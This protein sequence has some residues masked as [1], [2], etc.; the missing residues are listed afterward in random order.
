MNGRKRKLSTPDAIRR[1]REWKPL[2]ALAAEL[3][4]SSSYARQIRAQIQRE[5]KYLCE[6]YEQR[7]PGFKATDVGMQINAH[8]AR[9]TTQGWKP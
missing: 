8:I 1:I 2:P 6:R 9:D 5:A 4:M 3:G 7:F